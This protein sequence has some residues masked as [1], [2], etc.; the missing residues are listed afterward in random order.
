MPA[1]AVST[2]DRIIPNDSLHDVV[3]YNILIEGSEVDA[4]VQVL[5]ILITKEVNRISSAKVIIRD[6][7]PATETFAVSETAQFIPG[8]KIEIKVG[9]DANNISV[10]KG[11]IVKHSLKARQN[12]NSTLTIECK[13]ESV[14]LTIGRKNRYFELVK[15]SDAISTVLNGFAGNVKTTSLVHREIVQYYS[16]DWDFV[17]SRAEINGLLLINDAGKI[18][19]KEP[20]TSTPSVV[21]LVFGSNLLEFES[22]MDARHQWKEVETKAWDY[23]NQTLFE[24]TSRSSGKFDEHGNLSGAGLSDAVSPPKLVLK[25]SGHVKEEELKA[26]ADAMMIRSR[27]AKIC[28]RAKIIG[29]DT[30]KPGVCVTL[31][32]M[33]ARFNGKAYVT[34][35][36]H[37]LSEGTWFTHVQ[38]GLSPERVIQKPDFAEIP[39][40]GLIPPIHGLHIGVV[41]QLENDPEGEDRIL[42]KLPLLDNNE[43]GIWSR[44]ST[45]DAGKERGSFFLPE[46]GDEVIVGFINDDPRD[47]VILGM[48]HSKAKAAPLPAQDTNHIKGFVTRSKMKVLFDDE[49]SIITIV[50]PATNTMVVSDDEKSI[51]IKDQTGNEVKLSD[52]GIS[53]KS[54]KDIK[55][56]ATGKIDIKASQDVSIEGGTNTTVK[57][58]ANLTAQGQAGA[59]FS[60]SAIAK[61]KGSMVMIN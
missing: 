61:L 2:N 17:L 12:G 42:V 51:T 10:F 11:I 58:G 35:V 21:T 41:T 25:H 6:G 5:A 29:L 23:S 24:S 32:G 27:M 52:A 60:S 1:N 46:I 43:K 38:F 36:R 15:D 13:D 20:D 49:K 57:A 34:A 31:Q 8:K 40:G 19:V 7:D 16:T 44:V 22:D 47:A 53:M 39:A 9:R 56:E 55:I 30:V 18:D 26:W 28:G 59:E 54:P 48:V 3:S 50:T 4:T 14:K 33:G 45:L 37:E